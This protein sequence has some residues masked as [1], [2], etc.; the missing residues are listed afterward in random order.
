MEIQLSIIDPNRTTRADLLVTTDPEATVGALAAEV[1][2][3]L[4]RPVGVEGPPALYVNGFAVAPSLTVANSPLRDGAII[5]LATPNACPL[6]D[7]Q[8]FVEVRVAGGPDAGRVYPLGPGIAVVGSDPQ[9]WISVDDP[10]LPQYAVEVDVAVDGSV[11]V[12]PAYGSSVTLDGEPLDDQRPWRPR[13]VIVAGHTLLELSLPSF[14]DTALKPSEDGT[15]LDY[16]RPPRITPPPRPTKFQLPSKPK[17]SE[18]R[19]LPWLMAVVPLVGAVVMALMMGQ[20]RYLFMAVLSPIAMVGNYLIDKKHGKKTYRQTVADYERAKASIERQARRAM[21]AETG[22]RREGAPDPAEVWATATGPGQRL[23]E[24][25]RADADYGLLRVGTGAVPSDVQVTDPNQEEHRRGE[26]RRLADVPVTVPLRQHG[27]LGVAGRGGL[28]RAIGRWLVTQAAVLHSPADLQVY[29][30]TDPSGQSDW[31]WVR[32]LP[33]AR[34]REGQPAL[35]LIGTDAD[36]VARRIS[37]LLALVATRQEAAR[38]AGMAD[39]QSWGGPTVLVVLDGS[40]RLRALPGLT[41]VLREGP[42]V[43]IDLVCLDADR[44]LLPEECRALVEEDFHGLLQVSM[45]G[46]E[47]LTAVRPDCVTPGWSEQVAR[48]VAPIRDVSGDEGA[49]LPD[50]CRLLD[51][52]GMEPPTSDAVA[53]GWSRGGRSTTAV[54]GESFDGPFSIDLVRDG[55]H[56]LVAGTTGS[57]KSELLQTI[58]A[59]LA[60]ANRPDAMTFVLVDYKGGA[61][62]KDC[63]K[64]PHTVGMVTDLDTHLV[65]RALESLGAELRRREHILGAAGTKDL[66]DYIVAMRTNPALAPMPRLLI[67]IDEFAS[68]ARELPDFVTGLVNVAQRGRS[69]GIHLILA[70]QRP[71]GVVSPEI[72]ANTNLR[73]ALRVTDASESSDVIDAPDAGFI[74]KSTPGRAYVRLGASSLLPFQSGRVGGRRPGAVRTTVPA[75]FTVAIGWDGLGRPVPERPSGPKTGDD[76]LLTDLAVLVE[77]V[78]GANE[79]LGIPPQHSPW[80]PALAERVVLDQLEAPAAPSPDGLLPAPYAVDDLPGEQARRTVSLDLTTFGHLMIAGAPRSGRSQTLRTIAGSLARANS[81]GDVHLYALDCGNGALLALTSLPHCGA[82]VRSNESDRA[83][84]LIEK[85]SSEVQRRMALL[86]EGGFTDINEQR[87]AVPAG[88]RLSHIVL[89]LDR[90]E[91]F[92]PSLGDLNGGALQDAIFQLMREGASVGVH[93][94]LSGDRS[95]L[96]GRISTLTENKMALQLSD[97]GDVSLIGLNPRKIPAKIPAGRAFRAQGGVETHVALLVEDPSG[98]SQS[99]ALQSIGASAEDRDTAVPRSRRPFRVDVLPGRIGY[100]EAWELRDA[101]EIGAMPRGGRLWSMAAVGGDQLTALGP[102][103][104]EGTPAFVIAGPARSGR[105]TALLTMVRSLLSVGTQ[106]IVAAPRPQSPLRR[107][108][109]AE[110]VAGFF[111]EDNLAPDALEAALEQLTSPGVIVMDDAELLRTC[112]AGEVLQ[113]VLRGA[114]GREVG[115]VI[116]GDAE[117]V[118]GGFSGWQVDLKKARRGLLLSPQNMSDGELIGIRLQRGSVGQA[119]QP[120]RGLLHL[121]DNTVHTVQVPL[122]TV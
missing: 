72:R 29:V 62:F 93:V 16:N 55:P 103:L 104:A 34:A 118:C 46:A 79:R 121:G 98:Q 41:Q 91:G 44:R 122:T 35:S 60:V 84:R 100:E 33:H 69:L 109:G 48:G 1:G 102:D 18:G 89:L 50:A 86:G 4:G 15:G 78:Q 49:A 75:P 52:I 112:D 99:A 38:E 3:L 110:G 54:V 30:L 101:Q 73:I 95:L 36:S 76:D 119:V 85:L 24:R 26:A 12:R 120:G 22:A 105:S 64:L 51:V 94:V 97:P 83:V 31:E 71:S 5:S 37:E 42:R 6:P 74:A 61:A 7:P 65:E 8:G 56:G 114:A 87:Q 108:K 45:A 68:M 67:V 14:P 81:C 58:V 63:V 117:D 77:A 111:G 13:S 28:P 10:A 19:P 20:P 32:W 88:E 57:G 82:V 106:V 115:I 43:G 92:V 17:P 25:R 107:L 116:A 11:T 27:V 23:W 90:W 96:L 70:T 66:E 47:P 113:S 80:L 40:R 39:N 2:R 9:A 53:A 59:S 21:A